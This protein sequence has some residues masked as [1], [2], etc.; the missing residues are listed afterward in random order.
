MLQHQQRSFHFSHIPFSNQAYH[1]RDIS[2]PIII[3]IKRLNTSKI[4]ILML[5]TRIFLLARTCIFFPLCLILL[6]HMSWHYTVTS[7]LIA[8]SRGRV[9]PTTIISRIGHPRCQ[10]CSSAIRHARTR[11]YLSLLQVWYITVCHYNTFRQQ[12][13]SQ[14]TMSYG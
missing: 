12:R 6:Y 8:S 14:R 9:M 3:C 2:K 5:Y 11:R 10:W 13:S 7:L 4:M 1:G